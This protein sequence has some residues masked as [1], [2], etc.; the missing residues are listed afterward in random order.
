MPT[1]PSSTRTLYDNVLAPEHIDRLLAFH[2]IAGQK[3]ART[4]VDIN[5]RYHTK[6][7]MKP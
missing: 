1:S 5:P 7:I 4:L 3:I 2:A 6:E